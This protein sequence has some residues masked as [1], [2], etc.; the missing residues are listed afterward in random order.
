MVLNFKEHPHRRYNPLLGEYVLVSPHRTQRPWQ[1]RTESIPEDERPSYDPDCYLCPGNP[2]KSG[3]VNPQYD[4]TF[5]F[6][7]DYSA[8]LPDTPMELAG[9]EAEHP[10]LRV[11]GV[12]GVPLD[13]LKEEIDLLCK[14]VQGGLLFQFPKVGLWIGKFYGVP[15]GR[16]QVGQS[17]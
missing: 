5:V 11:E 2:R 1:G 13:S 17:P 14:G 9:S 4:S 6:T 3:D 7:N 12:Q 8:L 10:L 15:F 16:P